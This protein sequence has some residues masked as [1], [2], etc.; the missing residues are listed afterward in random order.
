MENLDQNILEA[1][2]SGRERQRFAL[3]RKTVKATFFN[4]SNW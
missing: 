2:L 4:L 1:E 3:A